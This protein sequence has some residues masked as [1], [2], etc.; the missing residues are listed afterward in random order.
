[1]HILKILKDRG[2]SWLKN[3]AKIFQWDCWGTNE[4]EVNISAKAIGQNFK[5]LVLKQCNSEKGLE[6]LYLNN[7][8]TVLL[9]IME[10]QWQLYPVKTEARL[11]T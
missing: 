9:I 5:L 3:Q 10:M 1:M 6:L 8:K 4:E 11:S 2:K 7:L